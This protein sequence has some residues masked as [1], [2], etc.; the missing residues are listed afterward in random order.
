MTNKH[1]K[2]G[3]RILKL[4]DT[5]RAEI[6]ADSVANSLPDNIMMS[7]QE[8]KLKRARNVSYYM[9]LHIRTLPATLEPLMWIPDIFSYISDDL[10]DVMDEIRNT[11]QAGKKGEDDE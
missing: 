1:T 3:K 11:G 4:A 2:P 6:M 7:E 8:R 10:D 5:H 9:H